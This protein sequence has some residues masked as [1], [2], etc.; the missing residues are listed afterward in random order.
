MLFVCRILQV[1]CQL[2][3]RTNGRC[4]FTALLRKRF[5]HFAH[6]RA[7]SDLE[8][9]SALRTFDSVYLCHISVYLVI[10]CKY[11]TSLCQ[12]VAQVQNMWVLYILN[13]KIVILRRKALS[14]HLITINYVNYRDLRS[15]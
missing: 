15:V 6:K 12:A 9:A 3:N 11:T 4:V 13:T 10:S 8:S 2:A 7:F 14:S 5:V 1:N